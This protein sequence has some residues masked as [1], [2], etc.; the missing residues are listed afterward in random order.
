M[1]TSCQK[2]KKS[3]IPTW[4]R[5]THVKRALQCATFLLVHDLITDAE[6]EKIHV[7]MK[8]KYLTHCNTTVVAK[9]SR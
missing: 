7:R 9:E 3:M 8:K 4:K 6:R 2:Y 1:T 5:T